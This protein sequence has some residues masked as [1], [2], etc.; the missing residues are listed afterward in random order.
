MVSTN[1]TEATKLDMQEKLAWMARSKG[2][3]GNA[4][5]SPDEVQDHFLS[6][7]HA[8]HLLFF[9]YCR[10]AKTKGWRDGEAKRRIGRFTA[11]MTSTDAAVWNC[12]QD[13]RT[14]DVHT[15][16]VKVANTEQPGA[17]M[18]EDQLILL[19]DMKMVVGDY[20]YTV[21]YGGSDVDVMDLCTKGLVL[22]Q[23]FCD[24]FEWI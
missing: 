19:N 17:L 23:R 20:R 15:Q 7:I 18:L 10:W 24:E 8:A 6:F 3:I 12:L 4:L 11:A 16:P 22:K 2:R 21:T 14:E 13:L 9:Y 1:V 5:S